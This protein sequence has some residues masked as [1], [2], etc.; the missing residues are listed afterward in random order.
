MLDNLKRP[1]KIGNEIL[2]FLHCYVFFWH[3][4]LLWL[5]PN[6]ENGIKAGLPVDDVDY[7]HSYSM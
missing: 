1:K 5:F 7:L 3:E 4:F 2:F 6:P